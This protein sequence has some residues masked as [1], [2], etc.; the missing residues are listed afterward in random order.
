MEKEAANLI[1]SATHEILKTDINDIGNI[2]EYVPIPKI[3]P[4]TLMKLFDSSVE[5]LKTESSLIRISGK[6]VVV[7]DLHGNYRDLI[8]ILIFNGV[9]PQTNYLFL[10]DYVDRGSF[11]IEVFELLF[12]MKVLF[13][14]NVYLLRGNHEE[15]ETNERYGLYDEI[16]R[17]Y[18]DQSI[19]LDAKPEEAHFLQ[20]QLVNIEE[21]VDEGEEDERDPSAKEIWERMN[22]VF[23][24]LPLACVLNDTTFCV[25]GG[26]SKHMHSLEDIEKI[27][28]PLTAFTPLVTDLLWS[29]PCEPLQHYSN[30]E[31]GR[32]C[33]FGANAI[34]KFL[35]DTGMEQIVRGHQCITKGVQFLHAHN[36]VTV[37]SSSG[38]SGE[39]NNGGYIIVLPNHEIEKFVFF[40]IQ[41]LSRDDASFFNVKRVHKY[42]LKHSEENNNSRTLLNIAYVKAQQSHKEPNMLR[43]L[44]KVRIG[45]L[46]TGG[47]CSS[48]SKLPQITARPV[49]P[50]VK[51]LPRNGKSLERM[52]TCK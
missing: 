3:D 45:S 42:K 41:P 21:V 7:G 29:D 16:Q 12:S 27:K 20:S 24:Y 2:G 34:A 38:Y 9:P 51:L 43:V 50:A 25:H 18:G 10:G 19:P 33:M 47:I 48:T 4:Q 49:F 37:F 23:D 13:P 15:K 28:L 6:F 14:K 17:V 26:I 44:S 32:G 5:I 36:F 52:Q 11:S 22:N 30:N 31:R 35:K 1:F 8:R 46:T 40:P 39:K